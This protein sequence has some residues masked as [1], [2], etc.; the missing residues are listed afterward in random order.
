MLW[1]EVPSVEC[2]DNKIT[3]CF[4]VFGASRNNMEKN[5]IT[6]DI[7]YQLSI[8]LVKLGGCVV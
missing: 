1:T 3:R 5:D 7:F 8:Y 2:S 6:A 4:S